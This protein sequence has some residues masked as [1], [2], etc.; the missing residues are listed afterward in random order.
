MNGEERERGSEAEGRVEA[1]EIVSL[2]ISMVGAREQPR[3]DLSS[4]LQFKC[5]K[6]KFSSDYIYIPKQCKPYI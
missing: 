5:C 2:S 3:A 4:R 6:I 1:I